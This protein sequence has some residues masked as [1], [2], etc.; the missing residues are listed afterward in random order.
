MLGPHLVAFQV[1]VL[2]SETLRC[3]SGISCTIWEWIPGVHWGCNCFIPWR[4]L[5]FCDTHFWRVEN[6]RGIRFA[7]LVSY[8]KEVDRFAGTTPSDLKISFR[9]L[10]S[11]SVNAEFLHP[12]LSPSSQITEIS[13]WIVTSPVSQRKPKVACVFPCPDCTFVI[14]R[15]IEESLRGVRQLLLW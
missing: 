1:I 7:P 12:S 4:P 5:V 15:L 11:M 8:R 2:H 10:L 9:R 14:G 3:T 13:L 6:A